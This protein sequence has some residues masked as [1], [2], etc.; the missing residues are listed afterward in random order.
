MSSY[1]LLKENKIKPIETKLCLY[2]I[3]DFLKMNHK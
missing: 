2:V 3:K 1:N